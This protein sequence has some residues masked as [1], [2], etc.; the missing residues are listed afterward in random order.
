MSFIGE[1]KM[2]A[3]GVAVCTVVAAATI[4]VMTLLFYPRN[5][6]GIAL[7]YRQIST[8]TMEINTMEKDIY[9]IEKVKKAD[10]LA[11]G[12]D[13]RG[14]LAEMDAVRSLGVIPDFFCAAMSDA[15]VK[16][17]V[18]GR[19]GHRQDSDGFSASQ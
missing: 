3:A 17:V 19:G 9:F 11:R 1:G 13:L 4:G 10:E 8:I 6:P 18:H 2:V 16:M 5:P 14:A 7:P 15:V 12:G